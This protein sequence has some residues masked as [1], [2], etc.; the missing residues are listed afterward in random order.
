MEDDLDLRKIPAIPV[1]AFLCE[2]AHGYSTAS[3]PHRTEK[4]RASMSFRV[5][6][7]TPA[8]QS[9]TRMRG[10]TAGYVPS[11]RSPC[12]ATR[13]GFI[14]ISITLRKW[15]WSSESVWSNGRQ[16]IWY[17]AEITGQWL[18]RVGSV[19]KCHAFEVP[20]SFGYEAVDIVLVLRPSHCT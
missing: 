18:R 19:R 20:E 9:S 13:A 2:P 14:S 11:Y 8:S 3:S 6:D 10:Y 16:C 5:V 1:S 15:S 7:K 12:E 4:H 17:A